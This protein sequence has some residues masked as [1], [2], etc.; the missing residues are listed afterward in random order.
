MMFSYKSVKNITIFSVESS[1]NEI[2]R[3]GM[4]NSKENMQRGSF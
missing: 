4:E 3:A 2:I 1:N